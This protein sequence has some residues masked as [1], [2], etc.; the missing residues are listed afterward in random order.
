MI[1][2][3]GGNPFYDLE[4]PNAILNEN[5]NVKANANLNANANVP[6]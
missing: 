4:L 2:A 1:Q 3:S 6:M 5:A